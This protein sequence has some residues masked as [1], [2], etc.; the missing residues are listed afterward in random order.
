MKKL[1][2][3]GAGVACAL[4][5]AL[6]ACA[7]DSTDYSSAL[8][9]LAVLAAGITFYFIPTVVARHRRLAYGTA[10]VFLVNLLIGWTMLGWVVCLIWAASAR[11]QR[12]AE[13]DALMLKK[14]R[15]E[16]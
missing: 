6:P 3:T 9:V 13:L 4:L 2:V 16:R 8:A 12:Q 7:A 10:L 1:L 15:A 14:L 5:V 11:T